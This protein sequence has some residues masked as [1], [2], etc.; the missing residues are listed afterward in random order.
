MRGPGRCRRKFKRLLGDADRG[1]RIV[2]ALGFDEQS[3]QTQQSGIFALGHGAKRLPRSA[4]V[5]CE[6]RRLRVQQQRQRIV[7]GMAARDIGMHA[8]GGGIAVADREQPVGDGVPAADTAPFVPTAAKAFR[9]APQC[10]QHAP[11][12]YRCDDGNAERQ[13]EYRQRGMDAP[14]TP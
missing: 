8:G 11:R 4:T 7:R 9:H 3:A 10:A 2:G 14:A 6:L 5:A 12:Q 13:C 1:D